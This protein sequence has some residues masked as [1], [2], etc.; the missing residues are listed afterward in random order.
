MFWRLISYRVPDIFESMATD[1]AILLDTVRNKK[2][3]TIRFYG[4]NPAA[5]SIGYFQDMEQDI[6]VEKCRKEGIDIVRRATGGR[7][8]FHLNEITYCVVAPEGEKYSPK[9]SR[10]HIRSSTDVSPAAWV[11]WESRHIW[12]KARGPRRPK[13]LIPVVLP[14]PQK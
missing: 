1:E 9:T 4:T 14:R 3:P 5:V 7:A 8:V 2:P 12:L 6:A 13:I 10:E 11:I